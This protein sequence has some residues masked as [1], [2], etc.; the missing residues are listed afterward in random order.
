MKYAKSNNNQFFNGL[1]LN[2]EEY[3]SER[4]IGKYG[5]YSI[6]FEGVVIMSVYL[7]SYVSIFRPSASPLSLV[8]AYITRA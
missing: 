2:V 5:N 3:F 6:A 7:A 1:K 4:K 8:I